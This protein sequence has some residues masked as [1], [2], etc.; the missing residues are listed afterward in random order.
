MCC[1]TTAADDKPQAEEKYEHDYTVVTACLVE[2]NELNKAVQ[3]Y[4][5]NH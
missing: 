5:R 1:C 4:C 2:N 3:L